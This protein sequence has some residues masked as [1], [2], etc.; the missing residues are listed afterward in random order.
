MPSDILHWT[1][2]QG[3]EAP[4]EIIALG[5]YLILKKKRS[6][7]YIIFIVV[8]HK[9]LFLADAT[10]WVFYI[11]LNNVLLLSDLLY[12]NTQTNVHVSTV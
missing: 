1:P 9:T 8:S 4:S 3:T 5:I 12:V 6:C 10:P 11:Y 7:G 2:C